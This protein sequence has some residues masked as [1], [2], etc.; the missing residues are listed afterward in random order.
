MRILELS[1]WVVTCLGFIF[2]SLEWTGA[3]LLL[4]F[5]LGSLSVF[6]FLLSWAFFSKIGFRKIFKKETYSD[7]QVIQLVGKFFM[8]WGLS[9]LAIGILFWIMEWPGGKINLIAGFAEVGLGLMIALIY[10]FIKKH[11]INW[12]LLSRGIGLFLLGIATLSFY[13]GLSGQNFDYY[14]DPNYLD[15][16]ENYEANPS[17]ENQHKLY[18]AEMYARGD[19]LEA[20]E[21]FIQFKEEIE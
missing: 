2:K 1:L 10:F 15:A 14:S 12:R 3:L 7:V 18:I 8:G 20:Q 4:L 13:P 17:L 11:P 16:L 6:Y 19:T 9:T 5:G 21:Y